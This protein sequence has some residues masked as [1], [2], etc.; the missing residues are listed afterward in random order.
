MFQ[1]IKQVLLRWIGFCQWYPSSVKKLN[2]VQHL[3]SLDTCSRLLVGPKCICA[4]GELTALPGS[5][6]WWGRGSNPFPALGLQPR[7]STFRASGVPPPPKKDTSSVSN[8]NCCKGFH[9]IEN[10][11]K[12][13]GPYA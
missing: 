8:Q 12:H 7:I 4:A 5:V 13:R 3:R 1:T 6:S 10:I 2:C 9:F 11:D